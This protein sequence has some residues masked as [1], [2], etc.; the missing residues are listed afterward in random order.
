MAAYINKQKGFLYV[1]L[2]VC[3][4]T[5][6]KEDHRS[7]FLTDHVTNAPWPKPV[8]L[9]LST[10]HIFL[11]YAEVVITDTISHVSTVIGNCK[12]IPH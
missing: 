7:Q 5:F 2:Y 9:L 10:D 12:N 1:C 4:S 3:M 11:S 6:I 8:L